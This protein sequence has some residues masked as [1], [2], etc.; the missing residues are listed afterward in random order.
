[1]NITRFPVYLSTLVSLILCYIFP[2]MV[3]CC[4]EGKT[5]VRHMVVFFFVT[6]SQYV[7][8]MLQWFNQSS[9]IYVGG[10]IP[11]N[12]AFWTVISIYSY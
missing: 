7:F 12:I 5:M 4:G 6:K 10:Y 3:D 9:D 2:L 11:T 1:V 8:Q